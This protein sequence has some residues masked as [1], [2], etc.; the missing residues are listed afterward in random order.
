MVNSK[1]VSVVI[2]TYKRP[3]LLQNAIQSVLSQN[4]N[5]LEIIIVDDNDP[6]SQERT[7]TAQIMEQYLDNPMVQYIKHP[8]N[9]NGAA[10][11]NTGIRSANGEF[12]AFLDDDDYY[13]PG[14]IAKQ[15]TY[16]L[17]QTQFDAVYCGRFHNREIVTSSKEGDLSEDILLSRFIPGPPTLLLRKDTL[18]EI[19]GFN[20]QY[21]RNQDTELLIRFFSKY[22]IGSIPEPLVAIGETGGQNELHGPELE[23]HKLQLLNDFREDID[24]ISSSRRYFKKRVYAKHYSIVF[25][26][27]LQHGY[28]S[29]A[30]R[31]LGRSLGRYPV[32]FCI[33]AVSKIYTLIRYHLFI[34]R[35]RHARL[36]NHH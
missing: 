13:L 27:H 20:E 8:E 29:R 24:R 4:Y 36:A 1:L 28:F 31:I 12:I 7:E 35:L 32:F 25:F 30:L 11:R 23:A 3:I 5:P 22:T 14:K 9:R 26:D 17:S 21:R 34:K 15:M 2:P 10:A 16:M 33:S 19:G 18:L 6:S